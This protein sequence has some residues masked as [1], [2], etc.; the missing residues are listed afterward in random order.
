[1][2]EV[3]LRSE[4]AAAQA[5]P[6]ARDP[7]E[8]QRALARVQD[9]LAKQHRVEALVHREAAPAEDKKAL[10]ENLVHRQ[11]LNELKAILDRLH[12]ADVAYILEALP[13]DDRMTVW[14]CVRAER[15]GE[16]L[17]EVSDA[18]RETLIKS[19][20]A[21]ELVAATGQLDTD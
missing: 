7:E 18:V 11:H 19:M 2:D 3:Q 1:M 17:L 21:S 15:D 6:P 4:P 16:I 12:P 13:R 9:L 5:A 8:A 14:E 10:V 20:D